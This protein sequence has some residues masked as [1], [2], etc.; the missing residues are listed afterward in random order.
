MDWTLIFD[1]QG[2]I[3]A[4]DVLKK[5]DRTFKASIISLYN[6]HGYQ[7]KPT[8]I[9]TK[10]RVYTFRRKPKQISYQPPRRKTE[11]ILDSTSLARAA[12]EYPP[13]GKVR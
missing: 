12:A 3:T 1:G 4:F 5:I 6:E 13:F 8:D 7:L 2:I 11:E 9:V 10:G